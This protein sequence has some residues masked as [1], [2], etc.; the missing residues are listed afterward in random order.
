[1]LV[2][3]PDLRLP[4]DRLAVRCLQQMPT[5]NGVAFTAG[6]TLDGD[7]VGT[8][9]DTGNGGA[10]TYFAIPANCISQR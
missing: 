1:M 5:H 3:T 9:E 7:Y 6:L 4:H 2:H 10:S 8:I